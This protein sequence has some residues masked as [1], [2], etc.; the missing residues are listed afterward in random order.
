MCAGPLASGLYFFNANTVTQS[1]NM[2][3]NPV[4]QNI[5]SPQSWKTLIYNYGMSG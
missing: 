3:T 5:R 1:Y 4:P 2:A